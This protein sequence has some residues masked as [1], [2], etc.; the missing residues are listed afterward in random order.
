MKIAVASEG[1]EVS[2]HFGHC[3]G[4]WIFDVENEEIKNSTFLPNPG[5]RPGFLPEY[6]K[7]KGVNCIISGGMG[8]SAI[9]LFNSYGID[10]IT[11]A[12]GDVKEVVE[13]YIK[14]TL[15]S[16]NSPCEEHKYHH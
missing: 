9:E 5:H 12:E 1:K 13:K 10:V 7:D 2:M 3:E 14:G 4:F 6:L 16:S 8:T 11:G 15:I